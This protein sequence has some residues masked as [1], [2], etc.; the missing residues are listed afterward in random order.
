[1][2]HGL[3]GIKLHELKNHLW[4]IDQRKTAAANPP[5][6]PY[7]Q[8][9]ITTALGS[10]LFRTPANSSFYPPIIQTPFV[11]T[12]IMPTNQTAPRP[13]MDF[14]P[15]FQPNSVVYPHQNNMP[16][17]GV[18]FFPTVTPFPQ[19]PSFMVSPGFNSFRNGVNSVPP[20]ST[21]ITLSQSGLPNFQANL[22]PAETLYQS[23]DV[24]LS[25]G[26]GVSAMQNRYGSGGI[27][28]CES[29]YKR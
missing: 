1:M 5:H 7:P 22:N 24:N 21:S 18:G 13:M 8:A 26:D 16:F 2:N 6:L 25:A 15:Q 4:D 27:Y 20:N 9:T 12:P 19:F 10:P 14:V 28:Y 23:P 11:P 17:A 3:H 29:F